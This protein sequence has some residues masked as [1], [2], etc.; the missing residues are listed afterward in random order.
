MK[1][2]E[3]N[4][5]IEA[6]LENAIDQETGEVL[7]EQLLAAYE[8]LQIDRGTKVE[9]IGLFIKNIESDAEAIKAEAKALSSRAKGAE[10]KAESLRAYLQWCLN[11]EKFQTPRLS[12]SY[13]RSQKVDAPDVFK[14]PEEYRRYLDPEADKTKIKDALKAGTEVPGATLIDSVSM[15]I[16]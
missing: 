8:Q 12:V 1:L 11:G 7:D 4:A 13:R 14:L 3:I 10:R 6:A 16:K 5:A 2:Y 9:N 15:I